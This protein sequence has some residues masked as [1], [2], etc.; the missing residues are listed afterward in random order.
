MMGT[1]GD[2]AD[3]MV[4][5]NEQGGWGLVRIGK[6]GALLPIVLFDGAIVGSVGTGGAIAFDDAS[7]AEQH[8]QF[9]VRPEGVFISDLDT[10]SGTRVDGLPVS[11]L[12]LAHGSVVRLGDAIALFVERE[13]S[14]F[15]GA[16]VVVGGEMVVGPRQRAWVDATNELVRDRRSLIVQGGP[17][18]GK[19]TLCRVAVQLGAAGVPVHGVDGM[20]FDTEQLLQTYEVAGPVIWFIQHVDRLPRA[21]QSDLVRAIRGARGSMMIGT[22]TGAIEDAQ[23]EGRIG[24]SMMGLID[25]RIVRVPDLEDRREDIPAIVLELLRRMGVRSGTGM[26]G[27]FEAV[28]RAGW[29]GGVREL[30]AHLAAAFDVGGTAQEAARV[31]CRSVPRAAPKSPLSL[32]ETDADLARTRLTRALDRASGTVAVA[33]RELK[34]SRQAFYRELR[35]LD[36]E[37]KRRSSYP[38][39]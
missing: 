22:V 8:A 24:A 33:A 4:S 32:H 35:R 37:S 11:M 7:V 14:T 3:Q 12:G 5:R 28:L 13:L 19:G 30:G 38:A 9:V 21:A 23:A 10:P 34:M 16:P 27:V 2:A 20:G 26:E 15:A 31:L 36:M 39:S 6:D 18:I 29:P 25:G 1:Q 17:G